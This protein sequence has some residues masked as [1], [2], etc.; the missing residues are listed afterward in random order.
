MAEVRE[1]VGIRA[2]A[3]DVWRVV[4]ED[5]RNFH[6]WTTNVRK[7]EALTPPP[8]G[9]GSVFRYHLSLPGGR[10]EVLDVEQ[11]VYEKPKRC[12]GIYARGP[13]R[14]NW[15]YTYRESAGLTHVTYQTEFDLTG[16]LRFLTGVFAPHY[17]AGVRQNLQ[18]L[19]KHVESGAGAKRARST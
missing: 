18:N 17:E 15:S 9:K 1:R 8:H 3:A 6:K 13:I 19:K 2:P 4:H 12:A 10:E 14:G 16:M 11:T 5:V 7:I